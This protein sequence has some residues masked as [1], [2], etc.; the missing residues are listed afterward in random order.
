MAALKVGEEEA[1]L[2][3]RHLLAHAEKLLQRSQS[4]FDLLYGGDVTVASEPN[5]GSTFTVT[6]NAGKPAARTDAR[7]LAAGSG[8]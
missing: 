1:L 3:E 5:V 4:A 7:Q 6:L 8:N 2:Q